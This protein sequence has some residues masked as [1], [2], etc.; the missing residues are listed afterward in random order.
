MP[1]HPPRPGPRQRRSTRRIGAAPFAGRLLVGLCA[2]AVGLFSCQRPEE[3]TRPYDVVLI[4]LDTLRADHLGCYGY[5]RDTSPNMDVFARECIFFERCIVPVSTTLPSHTSILT[6]VYPLEHGTLAN[7]KHDGRRFE[8]SPKLQSYAQIARDAGYRTAAFVSGAPLKRN[9]GISNGFDTFDQPDGAERRAADTNAAVLR[10]LDDPNQAP[11]LL[12]VHYFDPHGPY[13]PPAPFD[14]MYRTDEKLEAYL[15]ARRFADQSHRPEGK[16]VLARESI[17]AYDGEVRYLDGQVE[18]LL[19]RLRARPAWSRTVIILVGDHGEGL[20]QHDDAGHGYVWD[21]QLHAPLMIRIPGQ[22]PRRF[23]APMSSVDILPTVLG[24]VPGLPRGRFLEQVSG[25]DVLQAGFT[26][27][28]VFSQ[29]SGRQRSDH[30][31]PTYTLTGLEWKYLYEDGGVEQLFQLSADPFEL[32]DVRGNQP[33]IAARMR[34]QLLA[35]IATQRQRG[36]VLQA[37]RS[38]KSQPVDAKTLEQLRSLGYVDTP[39]TSQPG[40]HSG[41]EPIGD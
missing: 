7:I 18:V 19:A 8:P 14:T 25:L 39:V 22:A 31:R 1:T 20:C 6:G 38:E 40:R 34:E 26:P 24:Q 35:S 16:P 15:A 29:N 28:P 2:A 27:G 41:E 10:W 17:N 21:E 9:T 23:A 37:G 12:W 36:L 4:T 32:Q 30:T 11:M 13:E 5:F 3:A 33:E